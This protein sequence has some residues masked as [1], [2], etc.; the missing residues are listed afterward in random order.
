MRAVTCLKPGGID[1]LQIVKLPIPVPAAN[2]VLIKVYATALNRADIL[3]R[4]GLYNP[5]PNTT[6]ILGLECSGTIHSGNSQ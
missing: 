3:Q 6:N 2:E 5:P 4:R 1:V